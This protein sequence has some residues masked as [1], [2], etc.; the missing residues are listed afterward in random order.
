MKGLKKG[1]QIFKRNRSRIL[2][3]FLITGVLICIPLTVSSFT[4]PVEEQQTL[5]N[6][7]ESLEIL[8]EFEV[9]PIKSTL[10]PNPNEPLPRGIEVIHQ[11]LTDYINIKITG[12]LRGEDLA[13]ESLQ[14]D[15]FIWKIIVSTDTW[16][17]EL[18]WE[19]KVTSTEVTEGEE[20][21]YQF[22][23]EDTVPFQE[24]KALVATIEEEIDGR[25]E[26]YSLTFHTELHSSLQES[27]QAETLTGIFSFQSTP[28]TIRYDQ[29]NYFEKLVKNEEEQVIES[30]LNIAGRNL[31]VSTAR[32]IFPSFLTVFLL[33]GGA[34]M[35]QSQKE[36][37]KTFTP[38]EITL[39]KIQK[40]Y[41]KQMVE[42]LDARGMEKNHHPIPL[43]SFEDLLKL[44]EER[45]KPIIQGALE[46]QP[47]TDS[48]KIRFFILDEGNY[49]YYDI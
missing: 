6:Y 44:S 46:A 20:T 28:R 27:A 13:T 12:S 14:Q 32:I 24:A 9:Y 4:R 37:M 43:K 38:R 35:V 16:E 3:G 41:K 25:K 39:L 21:L 34:I 18:D 29:E 10:Y 48:P 5:T 42:T 11:N 15:L 26:D 22:V 33:S 45:E 30:R 23:L 47:Q 2:K 19:P 36:K 49:Y 8:Y 17:R 31:N 1:K 40:R 7:Q